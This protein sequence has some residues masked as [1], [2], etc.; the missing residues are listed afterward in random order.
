M[1][2]AQLSVSYASVPGKGEDSFAVRIGE[3]GGAMCVADGCGGLGGRR[4]EQ[5]DNATGAYLAAR[6]ATRAF[7]NWAEDNSSMPPNPEDGAKH[8]RELEGDLHGILSRFNSNHKGGEGGARIVGSMQRELPTTLCAAIIKANERADCCF[9]WAGDSR[10]YVLDAQGLHQLTRDHSLGEPDALESLYR[11]APLQSLLSADKPADMNM[12]RLPLKTPCLVL[13]ATDGVFGCLKTPMEF[14]MLLLSTMRAAGDYSGWRRKLEIALNRLASD[15]ATIVCASV[16]F[17]SYSD[18]LK[19]MAPRR[20]L[21]T[22]HYISPLRASSADM[23]MYREGWSEYRRDYDW[24]E[25]AGNDDDWR[26]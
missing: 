13:C 12:R 19:S 1:D 17:G 23:T 8:L 11:D 3:D 25:G 7:M 21:L 26:V 22:K 14:E 9:M 10:G 18:L 6:L 20:E 15:D 4:Y 5:L 16:G 2:I 24:T